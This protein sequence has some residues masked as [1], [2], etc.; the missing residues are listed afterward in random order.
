MVLC[1]IGRYLCF[2]LEGGPPCFLQGFTCLAVL[3]IPARLTSFRLQVFY[4]L[5][6]AFPNHSTKKFPLF[7]GPQPH[8]TEVSWFGLFPFRSPLLRESQLITFPLGT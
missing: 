3:W 6:M 1:A 7:A 8:K 4:L 5:C 2:A